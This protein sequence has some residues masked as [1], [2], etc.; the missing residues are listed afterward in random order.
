MKMNGAVVR[1]ATTLTALTGSFLSIPAMASAHFGEEVLYKGN[2][3]DHV[4]N[5]QQ[6]LKQEGYYKLSK[7]TGYFG[8]ATEKAVKAFQE[9]Q[10]ITVDGIVGDQT[11][12]KLNQYIK[13]DGKL[14]S[15]GSQ[16]DSVKDVQDHLKDLKFYSGKIDGLYG[17]LTRLAVLR[18]QK[19]RSLTMDGIVG[20]ETF[21]ALHET[22]NKD[23][24]KEKTTA[25][26]DASTTEHRAE[27]VKAAKINKASVSSSKVLYMNATA[28]T[29][30]CAG[31]SGVTATGINLRTHPGAKVVAVDP[32]TIPLG[33]KLYVEG[34]GYA[35]AGDTGGAIKGKR[36]D[37][38]MDS[39]TDAINW[40]RR[41]VKV[42]ILD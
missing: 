41:T 32:N 22:D 42:K 7:P 39:N 23:Q 10:H 30:Y 20:P 4:K 36:I 15:Y 16:G 5:L 28:Y 11:K 38:F 25:N 24:K 19:D 33:T 31:C 37:L 29:A 3:N 6:I 14:L 9:N 12:A 40:G 1:K 35:V 26:I 34:Y 21:K 8:T 18:F 13:Y 2:H 27:T 17:P